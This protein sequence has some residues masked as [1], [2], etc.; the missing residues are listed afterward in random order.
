MEEDKINQIDQRVL[1]I[2]D[3]MSRLASLRRKLMSKKEKMQ[4][5]KNFQKS[6][7]EA[8]AMKIDRK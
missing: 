3:E 1:E 6:E 4:D 8:E 5:N 7:I 2:D